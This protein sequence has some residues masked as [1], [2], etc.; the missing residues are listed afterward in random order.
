MW[1]SE[2]NLVTTVIG[3]GMTAAFI[4]FLCTRLLCGR[5]RSADSHSARLDL[6]LRSDIDQARRA[7]EQRIIG[8]E[9]VLLATIPTVKFKREDFSSREDIQCSICLGEYEER[10]ILRVMPSCHHNFHR[11]CI[12]IWLQKQITCPICRFPLKESLEVKYVAS[13]LVE[14][15]SEASLHEVSIDDD[16]DNQWLLPSGQRSDR[17]ENNQEIHESESV[18]TE[19]PY[20]E[21]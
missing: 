4:V 10:E 16:Q 14:E 7:L 1:A 2:V 17:N 9:P 18:I 11:A 3:F 15:Q 13:H 21:A 19:V 6:E 8:L 12:D 20:G 5:I